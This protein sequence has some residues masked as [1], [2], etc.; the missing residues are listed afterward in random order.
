MTGEEG[1]THAVLRCDGAPV[2]EAFRGPEWGAPLPI[3]ATDGAE[4]LNLRLDLL[5]GRLLTD[6]DG[7]PGDLVRIAA[8]AY[9]A[10]QMVSRGGRVDVHREGWRRALALCVPVSEPAFW[11]DP[12]TDAALRAALGFGTWDTW[13]FAFSPRPPGWVPVP[14]GW[15]EHALEGHPD[16]V[17]LFSG[18]TDSLCGLVEAVADRGLRPVVA[19]HRPAPH[20]AKPQR[21]LLGEIRRRFPGWHVPH[22]AF[23]I[24]RRGSDA[25]E[26]SQRTR[27]FLYAALGAAVAGR[28][29]VPSVL[30]PDNGYVSIN[31]P[32]SGQLVGS[33]AS[34]GTHPKFLHLVNVLLA[35][36]FPDTR[37]ANPLW[38]RTRAEALGI[39][40][41]HG[42]ADLLEKTRSC[43]KH[44]GR[45]NEV[46]HCGGCSQCVD[47]RVASVA[48][49]LEAH[50]PAGMYGLE[51]FTDNLPQGEPRTVAVSYVA[52]ARA[53]ATMAP[54][55]LYLDYPQLEEC[56]VPDAPDF[57][58]QAEGLTGVLG[59]HAT[60]VLAAVE[61]MVERHAKL[62][63]TGDL[64]PHS[65]LR[66]INAA[67]GAFGPTEASGPAEVLVPRYVLRREGKH[68][69]VEFGDEKGFVDAT[70]GM[71]RLVELVKNQGADVACTDLA[72]AAE[73]STAAPTAEEAG[74]AGEALRKGF[75]VDAPGGGDPL[76]DATGER[77]LKAR[78]REIERDL[79]GVDA[80]QREVLIGELEWIE[81]S[82]REARRPGG[83]RRTPKDRH[84]LARQ[85]VSKSLHD[86]FDA[87]RD[88]RPALHAHL[89]EALRIGVSCSYRPHPPVS[90]RLEPT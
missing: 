34:R 43:G 25:A 84:E 48:A 7:L 67:G 38:D 75:G 54:E 86:L 5:G 3:A 4:S 81:R 89:T 74:I 26:S 29:G 17:A 70:R 40:A 19:S 14:I 20:I 87:L 30:L 21:E 42:C 32:I 65:L 58:G 72:R 51:L 10:D 11:S 12:P 68:W 46:P 37:V 8:Y 64:P 28:M 62:I 66:L 77:D 71:D 52:F 85:A 76:L 33:L 15:D 55:D 90:W 63:A 78:A 39:L 16:A 13:R 31:P 45:T 23:R 49:G 50:D 44:R 73:R 82:L 88:E 9:A 41:A 36:V 1:A 22:A 83:Q 61:T 18:G 2:P 47:R 53:T 56:L 79:P 35:H 27:A 59:R 6:L 69:W 80:T 24:N 60:E 57:A